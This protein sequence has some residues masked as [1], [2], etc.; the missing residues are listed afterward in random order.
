MFLPTLSAGL[1][2]TAVNVIDVARS[3]PEELVGAVGA[4]AALALVTYTLT[5]TLALGQ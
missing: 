5:A 3:L 2:L 1:L 4:E